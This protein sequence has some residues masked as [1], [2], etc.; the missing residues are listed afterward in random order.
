MIRRRTLT[1]RR[2]SGLHP[3]WSR[4]INRDFES[5]RLEYIREFERLNHLVPTL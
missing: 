1:A 4:S 3:R 5:R 2:P